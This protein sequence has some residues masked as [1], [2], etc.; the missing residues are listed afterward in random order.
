[1]PTI[2]RFYGIV[3]TINWREHNPPHFHA[4]YAE[5]EAVFEIQPIA[6]SE[7]NLPRMAR[8]MVLEWAALHQTGAA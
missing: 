4:R 6:Q 5:F 2:C 1:V 7:G 3:I 8:S